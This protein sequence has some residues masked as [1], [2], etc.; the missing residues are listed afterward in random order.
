MAAPSNAT[1]AAGDEATELSKQ[2][3]TP[4]GLAHTTMQALKDRIK[5]HYDLASDYYLN[6]W[7]EHIHH[8]YWPTEASKATD[9]KETAQ[10]NLIRLLLDISGLAAPPPDNNANTTAKPLRILDVGCGIGGTSRYLARTLGATV[11]GITISGKQVQIATRLSK[12]AAAAASSASSAPSSSDGT[13]PANASEDEEAGFIPLAAAESSS[14]GSGGKVRFLELDA[15]KM[16][17]FFSSSPGRS[18]SRNSSS[19]S[20]PGKE[21]VKEEEEAGAFDVVWISEALSHFPDKALFFRNA[22]R[23]L[24]GGGRGRLVLADWFKAEGLVE[25]GAEFERDIRPIE[26]GMLLPPLCTQQEY[27]N[28]AAAAGLQVLS[29]PKD[30]SADVSKTWDISW[31]LVQNPS[32]WAFAFSQGRDGIAFLQA[33]RAM[34]RGY[35]NGTFRYAVMSFVKP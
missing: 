33:F 16:G 1:T 29:A 15:E 3:D 9:S 2:Y 6:L 31:S 22:H 26:D 19:S 7:G 5:L 21:E 32:L 13:T 11:T 28:M 23:L 24:R 27:V 4:L 12:S 20:A 25:G 30:I 34:R 18:S 14:S 10:I 8:G 17:D 35:A